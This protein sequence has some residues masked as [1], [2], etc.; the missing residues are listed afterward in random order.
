L[1][2]YDDSETFALGGN[3]LAV[4]YGLA[5]D[6]QAAGIFAAAEARRKAFEISTV[7]SSILPPYPSGFFRHPIVSDEFSYQN[8]GQWDWFAGRFVLAEFESGYSQMATEHLLQIAAR[9]QRN[10]GLFEW[11]SR[12][13]EGRGSQHYA[14]SAGALAAAVFKGL[15]G[16]E[17]GSEGVSIHVRLGAAGGSV[18]VEEPATDRWV[19]YVY[20]PDGRELSLDLQTNAAVKSIRLLLP[21]GARPGKATQDGEPVELDLVEHGEDRYAV[22]SPGR[23]EGQIVISLVAN[24]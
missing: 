13:G 18:R 8:G 15:Y 1:P 7:A 3:T 17:L 19:S 10:G 24:E 21:E 2:D 16:I 22:L 14:G 6:D 12:Q 4:L 9:V 11:Y 5:S 23:A 20:E